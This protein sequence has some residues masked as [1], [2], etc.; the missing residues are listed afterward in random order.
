[1]WS[2]MIHSLKNL[3]S[4]TSGW[5]DIRILKSEFVAKPQLLCIFKIRIQ[6]FDWLF[7]HKMF[8]PGHTV[9][10][11][12]A[13]LCIKVVFATNQNI[14][15]PISLQPHSVNLWYF[16]LRHWVAIIYELKK[17]EFVATINSFLYMLFC[18]VL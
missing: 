1:M 12:C 15:M 10:K 9:K 2:N 16:K 5:K 6:L 14:L 13:I 17:S 7:F 18:I 4:T 3:R 11:T 8:D